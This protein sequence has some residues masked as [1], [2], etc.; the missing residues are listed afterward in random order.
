MGFSGGRRGSA[1]VCDPNPPRPFARSR[2]LKEKKFLRSTLKTFQEPI[3][4]LRKFSEPCPLLCSPPLRF[5]RRSSRRGWSR[6][7][8]GENRTGE[9]R[10]LEWTL[11]WHFCGRLRGMFRGSFRGESCTWVKPGRF[12]SF[13]VLCFLALGGH[14]LQMLCLPGF[15]THANT[16]NLPHFRAFPAS[17]QEHSPPKCLFFMANA[18]LPNRPVF[19]LN[20]PRKKVI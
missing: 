5:F 16:Q 12:G 15:G 14:C 3:F 1:A 7:R 20:C 6:N 11:S 19:A 4:L 8:T 2:F 13:F 18:K 17:I 10:Q 9:P